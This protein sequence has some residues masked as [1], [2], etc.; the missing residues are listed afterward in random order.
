MNALPASALHRTAAM[1]PRSV[2]GGNL[3][4]PFTLCLAAAAILAA[5]RVT[6]PFRVSLSSLD[7][8]H[9][10]YNE[11]VAQIRCACLYCCRRH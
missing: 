8:A 3:H 6:A 7:I 11:A 10:V 9:G 1:L 4:R 2:W 5:M